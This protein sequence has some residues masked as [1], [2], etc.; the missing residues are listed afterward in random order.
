M[1]G[2]NLRF[3]ACILALA[4]TTLGGIGQASAQSAEAAHGDME[5][6]VSIN[7]RVWLTRLNDI[8]L[9]TYAGSGDLSGRARMCVYRNDTGVYDITATSANASE[10]RFRAA[11]GDHYVPYQVNFQDRSGNSFED[12]QSGERL[13]GLQGNTIA[14]LCV[15]SFGRNAALDVSF[16]ESDLQAAP[17]GRYQDVITLL[18]EPG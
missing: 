12:V 5:I 17:P 2:T 9:G 13:T 11:F 16:R 8:D 1:P 10:G 6:S 15:F 3:L 4:A 18:V 14:L 7:A